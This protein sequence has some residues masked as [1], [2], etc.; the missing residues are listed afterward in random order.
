MSPAPSPLTRFLKDASLPVL[1]VCVLLLAGLWWLTRP[2]GDLAPSIHVRYSA[3]V[4]DARR[5][6]IERDRGLAR[7][8]RLEGRTYAYDLVDTRPE[9]IRAIVED[10]GVEDTHDLDRERY[11]VRPGAPAGETRR[12]QADDLPL[13]QDVS[14]RRAMGSS[15]AIAAVL[16]AVAAALTRRRPQAG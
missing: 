4:T 13:L 8:T 10:P 15:L 14:A 1:V 9:N 16:A 7:G 3:E 2:N 5:A 12:S 6:E 11:A